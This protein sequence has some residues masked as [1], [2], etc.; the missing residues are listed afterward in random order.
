MVAHVFLL[1]AFWGS[2]TSCIGSV[3]CDV[4]YLVTGSKGS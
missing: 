2:A 3:L 4:F 1:D